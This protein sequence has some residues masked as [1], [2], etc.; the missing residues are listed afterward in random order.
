MPSIDMSL[1]VWQVS[2]LIL[3][4]VDPMEIFEL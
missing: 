1:K 2:Q 4:R 3:N